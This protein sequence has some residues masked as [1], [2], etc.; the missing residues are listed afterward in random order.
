MNH[1]SRSTVKVGIL[2]AL[3]FCAVCTGGCGQQGAALPVVVAPAAT[4]PVDCLA[5]SADGRML[6]A[7]FNEVIKVWDVSSGEE[8][9]RLT[10]PSAVNALAWSP[11]GKLVAAAC[12]MKTLEIWDLSGQP[13]HSLRGFKAPPTALAWSSDGRLLASAAGDPNP[14]ADQRGH[15]RSEVRLWDPAEGKQIAELAN[16]GDTAMTLAFAPD[17]ASLAAGCHDGRVR[18]WDVSAVKERVP[19]LAHGR[20]PV[21]SVAFRAD[22]ALLAAVG[23][24]GQICLWDATGWKEKGR[25]PGEG[26]R[27]NSVAFAASDRLLITGAEDGSVRLWDPT[28]RAEIGVLI[29]KG[30]RVHVVASQPRGNSVACGGAGRIVYVWD[31]PAGEHPPGLQPRL[32]LQY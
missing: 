26:T 16:P 4:A 5:F 25:L 15:V 13:Q 12:L 14:Y 1:R 10:A 7:N 28:A 9:L 30:P 31:L 18:I 22:G 21:L 6:A 29:S 32:S 24:D 8:R 20:Q 11:D 27:V 23:M 17:S 19:A 2:A 3:T